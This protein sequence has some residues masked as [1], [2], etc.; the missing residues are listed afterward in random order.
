[1]KYFRHTETGTL[2]RKNKHRHLFRFHPRAC[3][4]VQICWYNEREDGDVKMW[5]FNK[6]LSKNFIGISKVDTFIEIL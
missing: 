3:K 6:R 1:L 4:W 2:F 5:V